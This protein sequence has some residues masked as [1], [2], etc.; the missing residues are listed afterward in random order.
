MG[1]TRNR[2]DGLDPHAAK[3]IR[4]VAERLVGRAGLVEADRDDVEQDLAVA[5]LLRLP[6][7]DVGRASLDAFVTCIVKSAVATM[8]ES[9]KAEMRDWRCCARSLDER[10]E[11]Q[12]GN[13]SDQAPVLDRPECQARAV[14]DA[15]ANE[16]DRDLELDLDGAIATL[17]ADL[18]DLCERLRTAN[19]TE[20]SRATATP[21]G[22]VYDGMGQLKKHFERAGLSA[23]LDG[24]SDSFDRGPVG[25]EVGGDLAMRQR[26]RR[27]R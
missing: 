7:F 12:D 22:T 27:R 24:G 5:L 2:Y 1:S 6:R 10:G 16:R 19:V 13:P 23:Y 25:R 26:P 11:D 14:A 4:K 8:L 9:R 18:R 17:P 15:R 20:V 21:R 3:L